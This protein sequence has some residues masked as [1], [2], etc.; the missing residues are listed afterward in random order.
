MDKIY[1]NIIE[2]LIFSS[3]DP[4]PASEIIKAVKGIDGEDIQLNQQ[5]LKRL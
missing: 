5:I 4:L 3:D 1:T 2:A